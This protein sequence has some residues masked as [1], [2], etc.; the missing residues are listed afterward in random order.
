M[1]SGNCTSGGS[2]WCWIFVGMAVWFANGGS[3]NFY[4]FLAIGLY[5]AFAGKGNRC[6]T[7]SQNTTG[8]SE[9]KDTFKEEDFV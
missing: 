5:L 1:K 7:N 8:S 6:A 2:G 3:F 4:F 9:Q